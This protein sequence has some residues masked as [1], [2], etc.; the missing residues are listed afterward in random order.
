[1][2][3]TKN[4]GSVARV[5]KRT[6]GE[7]SI[8]PAD[9]TVKAVHVDRVSLGSTF[10]VNVRAEYGVWSL[11][12]SRRRDFGHGF[13]NGEQFDATVCFRT[14]DILNSGPGLHLPAPAKVARIAIK[15]ARAAKLDRDY[16]ETRPGVWTPKAAA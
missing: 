16:S 14:G 4:F 7:I 1:M 5:V 13:D 8:N 6:L 2:P 3:R 12:V 10:F 15:L 9:Y 11:L